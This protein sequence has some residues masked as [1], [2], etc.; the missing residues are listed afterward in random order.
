MKYIFTHHIDK[1]LNKI[2][3]VG[4]NAIKC[5]WI[6][7]ILLQYE[8]TKALACNWPISDALN[9]YMCFHMIISV[10]G[11]Y[12]NKNLKIGTKI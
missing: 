2:L 6:Q 9:M 12:P 3:W 10:L 4:Q 1:K 8:L 7:S 5:T 11:L